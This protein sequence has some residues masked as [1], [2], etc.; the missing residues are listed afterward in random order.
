[1]LIEISVKNFALIND[2]NIKLDKGLNIIM[3]E[4][5]SGKSNLIDSISIL[6]GD[7]AQK[8]KIR[9]GSD[10]AYIT[11][12]FN[13]SNNPKLIKY[14]SS[15]GLYIEDEPLIISR[16]I[17]NK[18]NT[19]TRI[20]NNIASVA[21]VKEI[22]KFLV[23]VYGQF[24]NI[25]ILSKS[26]QRKFID[27]LGNFKHKKLLDDYFILYNKYLELKEEIKIFERPP[28]QSKRDLDF[29]KFQ[30]DDIES[31]GVLEINESELEQKLDL[32]ENSQELKN[33][34]TTVINLLQ[35]SEDSIITN[36]GRVST[37][38]ER[39]KEIDSNFGEISTR[40]NQVLI[41]TEDIN[42]E[43]DSYFYS[44]D[45][46]E[47]EYKQ[48]DN[49]RNILFESKRKYGNS[50]DEIKKY[51]IKS[52][53]DLDNILNYESIL[54]D[55]YSNL[56]KYEEELIVLAK[57]ISENRKSLSNIFTEKI[58]D[59]LNELE[60]HDAKF[61]ILFKKT[62]LSITGIDDVVF[63]V[64]FNKNEPLKELS[65]VASGGEISRFM[66]AIKSIEADNVKI[67]TIIFD[68]IDTG[69]SGNAGNIVGNK[70]LNLSKN[71][72]LICI[73]HLPQIIAKGDTQF[74]VYKK[75]INDQVASNIIKLDYNERIEEL[76]KVI[77]G[78]DYSKHTFNTAKNM[79][80]DN[81]RG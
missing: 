4:T 15:L 23:D 41:E 67:P 56:N 68:E 2:I 59:Q 29:L 35:Y 11:G 78:D 20:N 53:S 55:K 80:D 33:D 75:L 49:K 47:V 81:K 30:I 9:K 63:Y 24:E 48:L 38:S 34:T 70:L 74:L 79:I 76:A 69:I 22:S 66:L 45:F 77:E 32:I 52:K 1:M 71:H 12:A 65:S 64:S 43:I 10:S 8:D 28:E 6:L 26:E 19:I 25:T 13:I 46:D 54:K 27:S 17:S 36:L 3:G 60:M 37:L 57:E 44:L 58:I 31:S 18:S 51:L 40:L 14:L 62:D 7:R 73:S 21:Q 72:Q 16:E 39:I 50:I 61:D 5:G 42:R